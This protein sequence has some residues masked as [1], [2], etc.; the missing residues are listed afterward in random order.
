MRQATADLKVMS[1]DGRAVEGRDLAKSLEQMV[2]LKR[3]TDKLA[4]RLGGDELLLEALLEG[5][6]GPNGALRIE[7]RTLRDVFKMVMIRIE[8]L[9]DKAS[10]PT[11]Q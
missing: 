4:R 8:G 2:E 9:L 10:Y 1:S 3:L 7:G 6:G 11:R 5:F